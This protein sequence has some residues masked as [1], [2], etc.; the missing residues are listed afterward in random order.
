M[1]SKWKDDDHLNLEHKSLEYIEIA[2]DISPQNQWWLI[3][4]DASQLLR[5][6]LTSHTLA[7]TQTLRNGQGRETQGALD[8]S[9]WLLTTY[10]WVYV[11]VLMRSE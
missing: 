7:V 4:P 3:L 6:A 5:T 8:F 10:C 11:T 9:A 1:G 2:N